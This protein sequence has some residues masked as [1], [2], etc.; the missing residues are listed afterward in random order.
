MINNI[1]EWTITLSWWISE[2]LLLLLLSDLQV[3]TQR[4]VKERDSVTLRCKSSCSLPQQTFIWF[5]NTQRVT[6]VIITENQLQLQSVSLHDSGNY[7]CAVSGYQHLISP[8]VHLNV[9]CEYKLII[10]IS[11][12]FT[13]FFWIEFLKLLISWNQEENERFICLKA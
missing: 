6:T 5:R 12:L 3:E 10:N 7:Q 2:L 1:F 8:P 11:E 9:E 4:S 13:P